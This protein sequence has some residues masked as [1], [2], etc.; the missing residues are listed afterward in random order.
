MKVVP[1]SGKIG[2]W[3]LPWSFQIGICRYLSLDESADD[4]EADSAH[5]LK[6]TTV[7]SLR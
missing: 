1:G 7:F 6:G 5:F 3:E 2:D 4:A